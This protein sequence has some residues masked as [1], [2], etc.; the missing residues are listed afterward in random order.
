MAWGE[1]DSRAR[2]G[3]YHRHRSCPKGTMSADDET[4]GGVLLQAQVRGD[5]RVS[6]AGVVCLPGRTSSRGLYTGQG[7]TA[8]GA[9]APDP[10]SL[11]FR[12][13]P[14]RRRCDPRP[15]APSAVVPAGPSRQPIGIQ[16]S[17]DRQRMSSEASISAD[18]MTVLELLRGAQKWAP[19]RFSTRSLK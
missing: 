17:K 19:D 7:R 12:W 8:E 14:R 15:S 4:I 6:G 10:G 13:P 2:G 3:V 16:A 9:H 18:L 5:S 1:Q 11:C